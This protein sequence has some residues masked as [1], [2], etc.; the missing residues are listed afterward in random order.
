MTIYKFIR[1]SVLTAGVISLVGLLSSDPAQAFTLT[2]LQN[3]DAESKL[4]PAGDNGEIAGAARFTTLISQLRANATTDAVVTIASGDN[5]LPGTTF[6]ASLED[7][8]FYDAAVLDA[9]GYDAIALGNHDFDFGPEILAD[10]ISSDQFSTPV[11]FLAANLDFSGEPQL[12]ALVDQGR[13]ASSVIVEKGGERI[14][15]IGAITPEL[16]FISSP[17]N[18]TVENPNDVAAEVQAEIN[19]LEAQGVNKIILTTQLQSINND[20]ALASELSGIDVIVSGGGQELL[21]NPGDPLLPADATTAP[22][23]PFPLE[24][25]NA[26]GDAIPVVT[27]TGGY[28]YVGQLEIEFDDAGK[29]VSFNGS[30]V[31]VFAEDGIAPDP[32]VQAEAIAPVQES[33]EALAENVLATSEVDLNGQRGDFTAGTPGVRTQETNLGNLIA[34]AL[35]ATGTDLADDFGV[36]APTIALQNGGGIRNNSIISAGDFTELDT[37]SILPFANFVS[38]VPDVSAE[39]LKLILENAVSNVENTDGRF[40]Q[41][42]GFKFAYDLTGTAQVTDDVTG[43][44]TTTGTRVKTVILNDGTVIVEDGQVV[45]GV[46]NISIATIDFLARGGDEYPFGGADFINLGTTYQQALED[47]VSS[48]LSGEITAEDYSEDASTRIF[49]GEIPTDQIPTEPSEP[50]EPGKPGEPGE[51]DEPGDP[52]VSVPEPT[53][54]LAML[55]FGAL[56]AGSL[57]QRKRKA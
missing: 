31:R 20:V 26:D 41:I 4:L 25:T 47:Y 49:V 43:E 19:A 5:I 38:I 11:P 17:R 22:F 39:R 32:S 13:V 21:A 1:P 44:I 12:Q 35:L 33:V 10:F 56:G 50:G 7:G 18:V 52:S 30:P 29:V 9:V 27:T 14:G 23:G 34:D 40:A 51:P 6:N 46:P 45:S 3:N 37:F 28:E 24:A 36:E 2:L 48:V 55:M 53:S 42:S 8:V 15:I 54:A 16:P 57:W